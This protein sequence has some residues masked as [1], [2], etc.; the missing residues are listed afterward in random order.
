MSRTYIR[1]H[2]SLLNKGLTF[3]REIFLAV[4]LPKTIQVSLQQ[5]LC[6]SEELLCLK[7]QRL[8]I[9]NQ[10]ISFFLTGITC[11]P[12]VTKKAA[13]HCLGWKRVLPWHLGKMLF[14]G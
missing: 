12:L 10:V 3:G 8:L 14:S 5:I 2:A 11:S 7:E 9:L 1:I 6:V 4:R 13:A